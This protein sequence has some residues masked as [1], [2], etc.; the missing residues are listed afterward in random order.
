MPA[1]PL[2][3]VPADPVFPKP[4]SSVIVV[5]PWKDAS[6]DPTRDPADY[7]VLMLRRSARGFFGSLSVFPGGVLEGAD[8]D[9]KWRDILPRLGGLSEEEIRKMEDAVLHDYE[10]LFAK[11]DRW[12]R[13]LE[14]QA[15]RDFA[16]G[17]LV[18]AARET[19]EECG[20]A[21]LRPR[22]DWLEGRPGTAAERV[23]A[24]DAWRRR[25]NADAGAF[26]ELCE[27]FK[28]APDLGSL[29]FWSNWRT[30]ETEI[31][32]YD[33]HFFLTVLDHPLG[34][35]PGGDADIHPYV[36]ADG[37]ETLEFSWVTPQEGIDRFKR[38]EIEL[39]EPQFCSLA[40][41][42]L[43]FP[44]LSHLLPYTP[45]SPGPRLRRS[46]LETI[47]NHPEFFH[48]DADGHNDGQVLVFPLD[49][50][51]SRTPELRAAIG[52]WEE[53]VRPKDGDRYRVVLDYDVEGTVQRMVFKDMD[54]VR[55][56]EGWTGLAGVPK[57]G[58]GEAGG[59]EAGGEE[60]PAKL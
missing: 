50:L 28:C 42:R 16:L 31:K 6:R 41:L 54:Y 13:R 22:V 26:A 8:T 14:G 11:G 32:T 7:K 20:I 45:L 21:L 5:S 46:R 2:K 17:L 51:H 27:H 29:A 38:D 1:T 37:T 25:V 48:D 24:S 55:T 3:P 10:T 56:V 53:G 59:G 12:G 4:A 44:T 33:A 35:D 60:G 58:A 40:E 57:A 18:A 34:A 9:A 39:V 47:K 43:R 15:R 52:E 36:A 23:A 49:Q 30:P 19:F